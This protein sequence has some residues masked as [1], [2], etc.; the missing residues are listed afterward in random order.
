MNGLLASVPIPID[1]TMVTTDVPEADYA[2][3]VVGTTYA[4]GDRVIKGHRIWESAQAGNVGHDPETSGE[5]WWLLVSST[6]RWCLFD[7]E[8]VTWTKKATSFYY[9]IEPGRPFSSIHVLGLKDNNY[10]RIR[11]YDESNT[12]IYDTGEEATGLLPAYPDW[13]AYC[14][15]P[16]LFNDQIHHADLPYVVD[17][18]IRIDF[19]G[20]ADLGVQCV[21]IG[22]DSSFGSGYGEGVL[23]GARVRFDRGTSFVANTFN[24]PT[25]TQR[26]LVV[27]ATFTLNLRSQGVDEVVD[28]YRSGGQGICLFTIR[29]QY[30]LTQILGTITGFEPLIEG[31]TLSQIAFEIRGVPQQ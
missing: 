31:P 5:A 24:I 26:A 18:K 22:E 9:E 29:D 12:L 20:G 16:W 11:I 8:Q 30:R 10:V 23:A 27:T 1:D 15:G 7:L 21:V 4:L 6:N 2:A 13:W 3:W 14:Y 17:G 19:A 28:F 25:M